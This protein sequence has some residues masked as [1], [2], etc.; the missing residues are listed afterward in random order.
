[1]QRVS[2]VVP[3]YNEEATILQVLDSLQVKVE[4]LAEILVV[5]DASTDGTA[6]LCRQYQSSHPVVRYFQLPCNC[7]KTAALAEGF[8]RSTGEI[9]IVQDAD[10]EYDP[11]DIN[12][13]VQPIQHGEADVVYGSRFHAPHASQTFYLRSFLANRLLTFLSNL[14]TG[15]KLSDVETCYKAFRGEII[16]G[17]RIT[18]ARFGFEIEVTAKLARLHSRVA[19]VPISYNGRTYAEGK[20]IGI[21]DGLMA[22][23]YILKYNL[24]VSKKDFFYPEGS[25]EP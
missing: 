24:L 22:L 17:M 3:A 14:F 8:R 19:E 11:A 10:L 18:S 25:F 20:K 15:M 4:N 5:D 21:R 13:V 6:G 12:S 23:W 16:R 2:V 9:V 7:G 1:M